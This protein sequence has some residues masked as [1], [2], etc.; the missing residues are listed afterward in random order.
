MVEGDERFF[1]YLEV[2]FKG[3]TTIHE[4]RGSYLVAYSTYGNVF[5][6]EFVLD[7]TEKVHV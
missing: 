4:R 1:E 3:C 7:V 5:A 6:E 2:S